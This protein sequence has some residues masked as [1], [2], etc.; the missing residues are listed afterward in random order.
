[1]VS[2][3]LS[4]VSEEVDFLKLDARDAYLDMALV[5]KI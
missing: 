4:P 2:S 5:P 3:R 1:M